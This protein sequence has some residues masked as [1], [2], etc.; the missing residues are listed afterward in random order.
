MKN[1][2][3]K[4]FFNFDYSQSGG[5]AVV[6]ALSMILLITMFAFVIDTGYLY[7]E[8]NKYQNGVEAAA[9]AG[10]VSLCDGDSDW[11]I[12][13]AKQVAK[14]NGLPA[15][16][17]GVTVG[18]YDEKD[19]YPDFHFVEEEEARNLGEFNNAVMLKLNA[20]EEL[21]MGGFMDK[22]EVVVRSAAVA[23]LVRYGMLAL[24]EEENNGI[25]T[26]AWY[27]HW[28]EGYP[29]F[30][31]MGFMHSNSNIGFTKG[32]AYATLTGDTILTAS[33]NITV[34][35][36]FEGSIVEGAEQV[37]IPPVDWEKLEAKANNNGQVITENGF[38]GSSGCTEDD[39]RN[40][41]CKDGNN[42]LFRLNRDIEDHE[43]RTYYFK[44]LGNLIVRGKAIEGPTYA[45]NLTIAAECDIRFRWSERFVL[46]LGG[47]GKK[48]VYIYSNGD[49]G[50]PHF[51]EKTRFDGVVLR[52]EKNLYLKFSLYDAD[53]EYI[54][55]ARGIAGGKIEF[56]GT[57]MSPE[58]AAIVWDGLFGPPCPP[59]VV[60]LG[61]LAATTP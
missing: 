46:Q 53:P 29:Q 2:I 12:S 59:A 6:V 18:F 19:I 9:M 30:K 33:G 17:I 56:G 4:K 16:S 51:N 37:S 22:D 26:S 41:L 28:Q 58:P 14:D 1:I 48:T 24:G 10:A 8:K 23:Y 27:K 61:R 36:G 20:T 44:G 40:Q 54:Y 38:P 42:F 11:V 34:P 13:V 5:V 57:Y 60:K 43:G 25:E 47:E 7:G 3:Y 50:Q 39:N 45:Y 31:D 52:A 35:D 15:G 21:L 55:R 49:I 32:N